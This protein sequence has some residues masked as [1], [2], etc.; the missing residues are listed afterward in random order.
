[1]G[2]APIDS[3]TGPY[4]FLSNFY[5]R[6][7]HVPS[8]GVV[9]SGEHGYQAVKG[10]FLKDSN[11]EIP[12]D[13]MV[14]HVL[15]APTPGDAKHRARRLKIDVPHWEERK[16]NVMV[17]ILECKF[18]DKTMAAKLCNTWPRLLVEGNTWGDRIWGQVNGQGQN[19]LGVLLMDRRARLLA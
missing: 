6:E 16:I 10:Y 18:K 5:E 19:L 14:E 8:L 9:K 17:T 2:Y 13:A 12:D 15:E 4:F 3:F 7:F 11:P 1:M